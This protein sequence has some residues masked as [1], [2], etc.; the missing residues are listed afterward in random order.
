ME[1]NPN[2]QKVEE[3]IKQFDELEA[4]NNAVIKEMSEIDKAVSSWYHKVEGLNIKHVS[5][6]H[7]LIKELK[8][9]LDRRRD[10]KLESMVLRSTCDT[11]RATIVKLKETHKSQFDKNKA[12]RIEIKERAIE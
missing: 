6:S 9:I 5:E 8:P 2:L 10:N 1:N 7:R 4:L 12:L 3:F 11:L